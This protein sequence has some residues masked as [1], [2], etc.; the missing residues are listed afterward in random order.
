MNLSL[1]IVIDFRS[2]DVRFLIVFK[3]NLLSYSNRYDYCFKVGTHSYRFLPGILSIYNPGHYLGLSKEIKENW[4]GLGNFEICLC[5]IFDCYYQTFIS[6]RKT[7]YQQLS[8]P[9]MR[10]I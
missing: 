2:F 7:G 8:L 4:T 9:N 3:H 1:N 5:V 10:F 6:T